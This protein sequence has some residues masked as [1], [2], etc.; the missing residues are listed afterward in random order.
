MLRSQT[1]MKSY[2][3]KLKFKIINH[4]FPHDFAVAQLI[5]S[6]R[7]RDVDL[8]QWCGSKFILAISFSFR[9][10]H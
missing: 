4:S 8:G 6:L 1:I 7:S 3:N 5:N 10:A 9:F 2:N